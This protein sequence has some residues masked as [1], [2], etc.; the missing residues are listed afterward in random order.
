ME[1][2]MTDPEG[3]R[4][5]R[6]RP[7]AFDETAV[8]D[9]AVDVFWRSGYAHASITDIS[10]ATGL[11]P[12]S[13]YNTYGSKL[14]LFACALDRYLDAIIANVLEPLEHGS[15]GLADVDAFFERLAA[16]TG[17]AHRPGCLAANTIGEFRDAPPPIAERTARYRKLLR[18]A[19][20]AALTRAAA[21]GEIPAEAVA[22]RAEAFLSIVIASSL[23]TAAGA[24]ARDARDLLRAARA[25]AA[26]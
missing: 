13:L 1:A 2:G 19:F 20:R 6:G 10:A 16:Q 26:A 3:A 21:S 8:L 5:A 25:L 9:T 14:E 18:R 11:A 22:P 4:R 12:S 7:R 15:A 23:L 24:P 17:R